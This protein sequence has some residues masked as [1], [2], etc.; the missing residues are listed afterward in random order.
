MAWTG[1]LTGDGDPVCGFVVD[2]NCHVCS[3]QA[4]T[5]P[6]VIRTISVEMAAQQQQKLK[7]A[8]R[9]ISRALG[10]K[11]KANL[12]ELTKLEFWNAEKASVFADA[13]ARWLCRCL[14]S[15]DIEK[16]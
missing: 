15:I 7:G 5:Q 2:V 12:V 16:D 8:F 1:G 4:L 6:A 9:E 14:D 11:L 10:V 3:Y 13:V